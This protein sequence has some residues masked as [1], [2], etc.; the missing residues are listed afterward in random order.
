MR[1][2]ESKAKWIFCDP[3]SVPQC[4]VAISQV[5]WDVEIMV[6]GQVEGCTSVDEIF[7]DDAAGKLHNN[8]SMI[9][10]MLQAITSWLN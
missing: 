7:L 10:K 3:I 1:I 2:Q 9:T 8:N 5:E 6:F 4:K